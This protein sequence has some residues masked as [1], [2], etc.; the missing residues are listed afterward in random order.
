MDKGENKMGLFD[1]LL[2]LTSSVVAATVVTTIKLPGSLIQTLE[3]TLEK[4]EDEL[5]AY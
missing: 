2:D 4:I 1:D 5:N 3:D